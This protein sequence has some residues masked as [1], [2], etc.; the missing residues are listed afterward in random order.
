MTASASRCIEATPRA[1]FT[2][3]DPGLSDQVAQG[4]DGCASAIPVVDHSLVPVNASSMP[5]WF[6]SSRRH[7]RPSPSG[8]TM[9]PGAASSRLCMNQQAYLDTQFIP[10]MVDAPTVDGVNGR[11]ERHGARCVE[12]SL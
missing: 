8:L 2:A 11:V 9:I 1:P 6:F 5:R 7:C 12:G 4:N 3:T 10:P